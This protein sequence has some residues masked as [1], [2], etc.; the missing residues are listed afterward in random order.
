MET[1]QNLPEPPSMADLLEQ[2]PIALF[3]DFDGTLVEIAPTPDSISVP[4]DLTQRLANLSARF[5]GRFA[6]VSGRAPANLEKHLGGLPFAVAGSHGAS[7]F[8]ADGSA[9]GRAADA[10]PKVV[11]LALSEF[12]ESN[13]IS[14]EAK[15]HG[16][17]LHFRAKPEL[18]KA[19]VEFAHE[20]AAQQGLALK[21][22][23]C[24]VEI[25]GRGADKAS[26]VKAFM[27][28]HD[29]VGATPIFVGDDLTDEDGFTAA[30]EFGGFG[31]A[32][33][34]RPSQNAQYKLNSVKDVHEWLML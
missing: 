3:L 34:D 1:S 26:A 11:V 5:D 31:V 7:R 23:K 16:G 27:A 25:V 20:L 32:V 4:S 19:A 14:Y 30:A 18:E 29:F 33:G 13:G 2:E 10:L 22:G 24:V 6:L 17:A 28:E 8:R 21:T 15:S 12:A 9:L